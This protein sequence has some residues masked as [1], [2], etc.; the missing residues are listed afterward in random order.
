MTATF[1]KPKHLVTCWVVYQAFSLPS[2][3][4]LAKLPVCCKPDKS[5]QSSFFSALECWAFLSR[6]LLPPWVWVTR[7]V[8]RSWHGFWLCPRIGVPRLEKQ[9]T[10]ILETMSQIPG[11]VCL[12]SSIFFDL[13]PASF[14]FF[15]YD[16]RRHLFFYLQTCPVPSLHSTISAFHRAL[17]WQRVSQHLKTSQIA[18]GKMSKQ[19][20]V[21]LPTVFLLGWEWHVLSYTVML[22]RSGVGVGKW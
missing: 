22:G 16:Y 19:K 7:M 15:S 18:K 9:R 4:V 5:S 13:F 20:K 21:F 11:N 10:Q 2:M 14:S 3:L 6:C 8:M 17:A 12:L 1:W